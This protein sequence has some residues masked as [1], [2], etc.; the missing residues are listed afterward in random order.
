MMS[1]QYAQRCLCTNE[2]RGDHVRR[3]GYLR[4]L[5]L[6]ERPRYGGPGAT[7]SML[8][9]A[10]TWGRGLTR[11]PQNGLAAGEQASPEGQR[12]RMA[13]MATDPKVF[14]RDRRVFV[15]SELE[16]RTANSS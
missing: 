2:V 6:Q 11:A 3:L 5:C 10:E 14:F 15:G 9:A 16:S 4:S 13:P 12:S 8:D 1:V 7:S